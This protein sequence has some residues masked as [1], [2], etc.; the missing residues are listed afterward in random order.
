MKGF[1]WVWTRACTWTQENTLIL[2]DYKITRWSD[3]EGICGEEGLATALAAELE[4]AGVRLLVG[5]EVALGD[6]EE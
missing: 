1:S 3:L 2:G 5:L 6:E 4:V